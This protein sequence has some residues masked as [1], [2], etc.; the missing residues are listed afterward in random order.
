MTDKTHGA[1]PRFG[2]VSSPFAALRDR[3]TR[4]SWLKSWAIPIL[5][6]LVL[7]GTLLSDSGGMIEIEPGEVAVKYNNTGLSL[8]GAK[9][10][11]INQQGMLFFLPGIHR[12]EKLERR[13][14]IFTMEGDVNID[15]SRA[16]KLTVRANDGS[17]FYFEKMEIHYQVVPSMAPQVIVDNGLGEGYKQRALLTHAREVLRDEFGRFSFLDIAD[18]TTY[19]RAIIGARNELNERLKGLGLEVTQVPNPKPRFEERVEKAIEDR[20]RAEQEVEVQQE[21]RRKLEQEKGRKIQEVEQAKSQEYQGLLA[22]LEGEKQKAANAQIAAQREADKYS[23]ERN[24]AGEAYRQEKMTRARANEE[25]Y[26]RQAEALVAKIKAVG[27][28]G[29]EVLNKVIA[30]QIFPQLSKVKATPLLRP[31]APIDIRHI[32][33]QP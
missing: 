33:Q 28:Q 10:E 32:Q 6:L 18:P 13:P 31:S 17:N 15:S 7:V 9:E 24:A 23:I 14:Q 16:S 27:A 29:S 25:A 8:F 11:V 12:V 30:E 5:A 22:A 3:T 20:Q 19:S 21:K 4:I 2:A 26:R 1:A